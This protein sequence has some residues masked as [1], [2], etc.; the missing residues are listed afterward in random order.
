MFSQL[1][2]G[3]FFLFLRVS[4]SSKSFPP[5]LSKKEESEYFF[6]MQRGDM[7]A[8]DTL[9]NRNLR[10]VAHI[11]KKYSS[12]PSEADDIISVGTIGLIKAIDSYK[13]ECGTRFATYAVR[14]LQNEI[15]MYFRSQ[16]KHLADTSLNEILDTDKEGNPLTYMD[17]LSIDDDIAER[18]DTKIKV[19]QLM[20]C[21]DTILTK[22]EK[23][24]IYMRYAL[25]FSKPMTQ[26][27][28]A[29]KLKISRSYVSRIENGAID[30]LK[31][32]F[33]KKKL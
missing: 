4:G 2:S 25:G 26:R 13:P 16:K 9:I 15:L 19:E 1:F 30:K 11:A 3:V 24:I 5:P 6:R 27:E 17:I 28:I 14:C 23:Q 32:E 21:I 10:L 29:Q 8:R 20:K 7:D 12:S 31:A 18:I 33:Q 22:R